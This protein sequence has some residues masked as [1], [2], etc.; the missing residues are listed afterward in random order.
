MRPHTIVFITLLAIL[1]AEQIVAQ[2]PRKLSPV[3][4]TDLD[5][6]GLD[7]AFEQQVLESHAP[8]IWMARGDDRLPCD[9]LWFVQHSFLEYEVLTYS[10]G[11]PIYTRTTL[12]D[13]PTLSAHPER[14][15]S[16]VVDVAPHGRRTS[17]FLTYRRFP[18]VQNGIGIYLNLNNNSFNGQPRTD[19]LARRN[20]GMV[21]HVAALSV[22]QEEYLC[23][24]YWQLFAY[25]DLD[26]GGPGNHEGDW[27]MYEQFIRVG[28]R[29]VVMAVWYN[30]GDK[31]IEYISGTDP[32]N[33]RTVGGDDE[34][35]LVSFIPSR[36]TVYVGYNDHEFYRKRLFVPPDPVLHYQTTNI[37]NMGEIL[38]PMPG[39]EI[40]C[41]YNGSWGRDGTNTSLNPSPEGIMHNSGID[42]QWPTE[43]QIWVDPT[44]TWANN[45]RYPAGS[46]GSPFT[47]L[48]EAATI[49]NRGALNVG[50]RLILVRPGSSFSN[51]L[52][53]DNP[54]HIIGMNQ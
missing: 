7:D 51:P 41:K 16:A 54:C 35:Y 22:A 43:T 11:I 44:G 24:Q 6:D 45:S 21:G 39:H 9:Y 3:A 8:Y 30:H 32:S 13:E 52:Q 25:N 48:A 31:S 50:E 15:L 40:L 4:T 49:V 46:A 53:I 23:V 34:K 17:D 29:V 36:D 27:N 33:F 14:A 10:G 42:W 38:L 12:I 28:D 19:V 1:L 2:T 5:Y 18:W 20:V 47:S 26:Y 37:P